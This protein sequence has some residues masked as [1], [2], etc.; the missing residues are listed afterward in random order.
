MI[1]DYVAYANEKRGI[2]EVEITAAARSPM[3]QRAVDGEA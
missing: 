2:V 3:S 1:D